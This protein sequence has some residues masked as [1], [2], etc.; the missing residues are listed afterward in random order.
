M[1]LPKRIA[2]LLMMR[3]WER[4]ASEGILAIE[5]VKNLNAV[6]FVWISPAALSHYL[7]YVGNFAVKG[8]DAHHY[9]ARKEALDDE[10][11]FLRIYHRLDYREGNER[12]NTGLLWA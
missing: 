1:S 12:I 7:K 3:K 11:P 6:V 5:F 9:Y 8:L 10:N 2:W 4:Q